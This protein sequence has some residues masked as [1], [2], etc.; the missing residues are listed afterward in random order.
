MRLPPLFRRENS[1]AARREREEA[2]ERVVTQGLRTLA[3]LL[4]KMADLIEQRRLERAGYKQPP[5]Q[6]L[7]RTAKPGQR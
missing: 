6:F 5:E 1:D 2:M 7:E 4:K 3:D